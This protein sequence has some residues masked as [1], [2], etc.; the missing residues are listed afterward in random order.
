M[1]VSIFICRGAVPLRRDYS[2]GHERGR[3]TGILRNIVPDQNQK[4]W[5]AADPLRSHVARLSLE[6]SLGCIQLTTSVSVL[7]GRLLS[8]VQYSTYD[9][10]LLSS[11]SWSW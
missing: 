9:G 11:L 1:R 7:T 5:N 3:R 2:S 8:E 10:E 4:Q 6:E